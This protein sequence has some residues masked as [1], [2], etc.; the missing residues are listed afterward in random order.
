M[1]RGNC[2]RRQS[3]NWALASAVSNYL[4]EWTE[5]YGIESDFHCGFSG[6][7]RTVG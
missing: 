6:S 7:E 2:G 3:T 4:V 5:Q 1:S